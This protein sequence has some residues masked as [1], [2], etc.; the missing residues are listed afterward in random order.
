MFYSTF[1][2][3]DPPGSGPM[4]T[5]RVVKLY[6][7]SPTPI[8]Y[9]VPVSKVLGQV[10]LMPSFLRGNS[11]HTIPHCFRSHTAIQTSPKSRAGREATSRRS[12]T[13]CGALG[14]ASLVW[15]VC[16]CQRPGSGEWLWCKKGLGVVKTPGPKGDTMP[17]RRQKSEARN[18]IGLARKDHRISMVVM[19]KRYPIDIFVCA[20]IS[21]VYYL[22]WNLKR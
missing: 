1:E 14:G 16:Q 11:K 13:G 20:K 3:L 9:V 6:E 7:P 19:S 17:P 5:H 4:E 21:P 12:T 18:E 22:S 15:G 2:V 8:L 10:P